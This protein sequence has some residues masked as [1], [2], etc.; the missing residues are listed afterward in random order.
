LEEKN[1]E[2]AV[3]EW[4]IKNKAKKVTKDPLAEHQVVE[5]PRFFELKDLILIADL[6]KEWNSSNL[7]LIQY[8]L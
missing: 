6:L 2:E 4:L 8:L 5:R 1:T 7:K 3:K